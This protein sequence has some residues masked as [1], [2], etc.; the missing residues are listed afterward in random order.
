MTTNQK[1]GSKLV[2]GFAAILLAGAV[3]TPF[4]LMLLCIEGLIRKNSPPVLT[5]KST[6]AV[7]IL[8]LPLRLDTAV[9]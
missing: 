5:T 6:R 8:A 7:I 9:R 4:E 3:S 2:A 1:L